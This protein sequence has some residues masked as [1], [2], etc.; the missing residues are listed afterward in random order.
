MIF[1]RVRTVLPIASISVREQD[2]ESSRLDNYGFLYNK[3]D[4]CQLNLDKF[5]FAQQLGISP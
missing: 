1:I 3:S 5:H 4:V 2:L